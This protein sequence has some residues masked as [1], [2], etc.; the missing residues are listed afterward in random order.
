[1][2]YEFN[3]L[4]LAEKLAVTSIPF[5]FFFAALSLMSFFKRKSVEGTFSNDLFLWALI[6]LYCTSHDLVGLFYYT[7]VVTV[8]S[9]LKTKCCSGSVVLFQWHKS[10]Q[11]LVGARSSYHVALILDGLDLLIQNLSHLLLLLKH[12]RIYHFKSLYTVLL[13]SFLDM[14]NECYF[15]CSAVN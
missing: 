7:A 13:F 1:M 8:T 2:F 14:G 11:S 10:P 12:F 4:Y 15:C 5:F 9:L 3:E 6:F